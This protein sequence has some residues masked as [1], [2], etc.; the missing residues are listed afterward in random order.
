MTT[1][2]TETFLDE[3]RA[4][5]DALD[6]AL[7]FFQLRG[8]HDVARAFD[9]F[10]ERRVVGFIRRIGVD[11]V[12]RDHF[13]TR[14]GEFGKGLRHQASRPGEPPEAFNARFIDRHDDDFVRRNGRPASADERVPRRQFQSRRAPHHNQ[15]RQRR[16]D[17]DGDRPDD[18]AA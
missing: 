11:H 9:G 13:R 8:D 14:V 6:V 2:F 1:T 15:R 10:S 16:N 17:D 12:E 7:R 5:L 18:C 3:T 4:I